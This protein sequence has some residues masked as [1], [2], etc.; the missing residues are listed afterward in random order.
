MPEVTPETAYTVRLTTTEFKL[1]TRA[2]AGLTKKGKERAEAFDLN[3]RLAKSRMNYL[4]DQAAAANAAYEAAA[5]LADGDDARSPDA[6]VEEN[7]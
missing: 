7:E 3:A 1:V 4:A 5:K 2:L 6:D